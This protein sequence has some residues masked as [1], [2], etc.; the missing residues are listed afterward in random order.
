M[1]IRDSND[2]EDMKKYLETSSGLLRQLFPKITAFHLHHPGKDPS[3]EER[4]SSYLRGNAD[5][6]IETKE[7][8]DRRFIYE[9]IKQ[10]NGTKGTK[11][12]FHLKK[13]QIGVNTFT[14]RTVTRAVAN[15]GI[16]LGRA[17][18]EAE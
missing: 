7:E 3:R 11:L 18:S 5:T 17:I 16:R 6:R 9:F 13:I 12:F 2:E 4:G 15:E 10:K 1:C 8:N 14:V